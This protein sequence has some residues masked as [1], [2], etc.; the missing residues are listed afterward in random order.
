M[1]T[2]GR[3]SWFLI[4][5]RTVRPSISGISMS[6]VMTS[7][8]NWAMRSSAMTPFEAAPTTSRAGSSD[9]A[10]VT[11]RRMTTESST[12][13]TRTRAPGGIAFL[14]MLV[15]IGPLLNQARHLLKQARHL[16]KQA[17]HPQLVRQ[18]LLGERLHHV[19][20]SSRG[21]R[22]HHLIHLCLGGDHHHLHGRVARIGA[23]P[24]EKLKS[25]HARHVPIHENQR[26]IFA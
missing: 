10:W 4:R 23:Q 15:F 25:V 13:S 16:L 11:R 22:L 14:K 9:S 21:Q 24:L 3:T 2:R 19:F 5:R 8:F 6:R 1:T 7:G 18:D 17:Q 26:E 20:I 12:T